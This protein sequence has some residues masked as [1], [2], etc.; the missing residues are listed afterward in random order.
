MKVIVEAS[1]IFTSRIAVVRPA[2]SGEQGEDVGLQ[3]LDFRF[4]G[5]RWRSVII[6]T[7]VSDG[8]ASAEFPLEIE[9]SV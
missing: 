7:G 9:I 6:G 3:A 8:A 1:G 5:G 4:Y 2:L